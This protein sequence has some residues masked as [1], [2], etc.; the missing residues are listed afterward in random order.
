MGHESA[1]YLAANAPFWNEFDGLVI[2]AEV[3]LVKP[4]PAIFEYLLKNIGL[5]NSDCIFI[6]DSLTNARVA[7]SLGIKSIHFQSLTQMTTELRKYI[8]WAE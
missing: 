8:S 5:T 3:Q 7:E 4:D 2:S 6:D 1:A